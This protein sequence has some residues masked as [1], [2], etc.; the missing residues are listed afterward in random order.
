MQLFLAHKWKIKCYD[1]VCF[2]TFRSDDKCHFE[3]LQFGLLITK[4]D[5]VKRLKISF[6]FK[7]FHLI[8]N[9]KQSSRRS[10]R[11][12]IAIESQKERRTQARKRK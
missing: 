3:Y 8:R 12:I 5:S 10:K 1:F 2:G 11:V 9:E 4:A 6:V 7:Q